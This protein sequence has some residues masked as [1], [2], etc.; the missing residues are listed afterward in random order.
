MANALVQPEK[1]RRFALVA[2]SS[3]NFFMHASN[4]SISDLSASRCGDPFSNFPHCNCTSA[5]CAAACLCSSSRVIA[6]SPFFLMH[7]LQAARP[8]RRKVT[9]T[10]DV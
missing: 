2:I 1:V 4:R 6:A 10:R 9:S 8:H 3:F 5:S 7:F